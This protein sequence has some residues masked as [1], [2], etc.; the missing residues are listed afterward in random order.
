MELNDAHVQ[1]FE[2]IEAI[3]ICWD[4]GKDA[5]GVRPRWLD[6]EEM[7]LAEIN[8]EIAHFADVIEQDRFDR[9]ADEL[10]LAEA[11]AQRKRDNA[12]VPNAAMALAFARAA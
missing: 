7:S 2:Y 10:A 9:E 6:F 3:E 11:E 12:Y 5:C 8:S 1:L 4:I